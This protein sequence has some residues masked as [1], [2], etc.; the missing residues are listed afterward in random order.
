MET[1][2]EHVKSSKRTGSIEFFIEERRKDLVV[3][4]MPITD[5]MRNPFG[6]VQAGALIWLADVT[7]SILVLEGQ[8]LDEEGRGFP[9]A[10]DVHTALVGN[11]KDGVISAEARFVKKGRKVF[12]V[13][14]RVVGNEGK[15]L[16]EVTS[17]HVAAG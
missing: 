16:A 3:S 13:R 9:L 17:T 7:A 6:V 5:G 4:R 2:H 1:L 10:I 15:L 14:T 8:V 12:V 11:Q